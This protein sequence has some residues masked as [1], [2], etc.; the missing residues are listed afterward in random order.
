MCE[1][2]PAAG[3]GESTESRMGPESR[4]KIV[5]GVEAR[6]VFGM[7][8]PSDCNR[9]KV[10]R[11]HLVG[12]AVPERRVPLAAARVAGRLDRKLKVISTRGGFEELDGLALRLYNEAKWV[13]TSRPYK[14]VDMKLPS[15]ETVSI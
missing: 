6:L 10:A 8:R 2:D 13:V 9:Q 1:R 14:P 5:D 12:M 4:S 7:G 3:V 11:R 15:Q